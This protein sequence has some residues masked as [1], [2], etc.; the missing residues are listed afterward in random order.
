MLSNKSFQAT[1]LALPPF[2]LKMGL[3]TALQRGEGARENYKTTS[4]EKLMRLF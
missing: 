4:C 2:P 3:A 1:F